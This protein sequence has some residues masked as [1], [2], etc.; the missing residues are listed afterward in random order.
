MTTWARAA[1]VLLA[2]AGCDEAAPDQG[3][4]TGGIEV[5]GGYAFA[6]VS[7]EAAAYLS[8]S[9]GDGAADTLLTV[10]TPYA[11]RVTLHD[12]RSDGARVRMEELARLELPGGTSVEMEPGGLHLMLTDLKVAL[13]V[14]HQ[15][16]L[17]LTFAR[18]G[19]M[20]IEI[21]IERYGARP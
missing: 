20:N 11:G 4:P 19:V 14:G 8:L 12:S 10:T 9:N 18:A 2:L 17:T 5:I 1:T 7:T 3:G 6:P 15:L 13:P 21:P 16:P